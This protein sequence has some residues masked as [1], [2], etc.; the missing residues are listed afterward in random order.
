MIMGHETRIALRAL[1]AV[2]DPALALAIA[3]ALGGR[4]DDKSR[5]DAIK[6]L[7]GM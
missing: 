2:G 4:L 5:N 1:L 6:Q 7:S 3:I